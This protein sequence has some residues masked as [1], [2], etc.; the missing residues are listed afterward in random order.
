MG[1]FKEM[2]IDA[3]QDAEAVGLQFIPIVNH[4]IAWRT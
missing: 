3:H 4:S 1:N 2:I